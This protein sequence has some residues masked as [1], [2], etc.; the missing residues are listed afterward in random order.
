VEPDTYDGLL[1]RSQI[2]IDKTQTVP[3]EKIGKV[4]GFLDDAKMMEVNRALA[5][6]VG[7][8]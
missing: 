5:L 7:F 1:K 3:A 6:W 8:A 2:M 4:I